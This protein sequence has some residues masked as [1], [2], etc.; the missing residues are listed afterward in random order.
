MKK[1][2]SIIAIALFALSSCNDTL[3]VAPDGRLTLDEVFK[4]EEL[5]KAYFSTCYNYLPKKGLRYHF[6]SNYPIALSDE[7]WDCTDGS[8]AGFA[9]AVS[10]NCT[11][12]DFYLDVRRDM[13]DT[14]SEGGYWQLYWGQIRT[15]NNFLKYA[16]TAAISKDT[17]RKR[18]IA[19][20]H[21]L[22][23]YFY[24]ELLKWYGPV[25]IEKENYGLT[26]DYSGMTRPSFEECARFI[27]D[28]CDIA[29]KEDNLPWRLTTLNERIR[30]TKGIAEAIRSEASLF[31][32]STFNNGGKD[33]WQWAYEVNKKSFDQLKANGYELY[34]KCV[35]KSK[36]YDNAYME[37][38]TLNNYIG[39]DPSDKETIWQSTEG[40]W[41][42][43]YTNPLYDV[44]GSP[45]LGNAIVTIVPSQELVDAYDM[46]ATGKPV[47]DL[48]KPYNDEKHLQPN[49]N[50]N[51]GYDKNNPYEGRDPRLRATV[52]YNNAPV[53]L[54]QTPAV[55]EIYVGGNSELRPSGNTNTRTGYYWRKRMVNGN[56]KAAGV[57]GYDGRFRF[58]RLGKIYLNLAEAAIED[59]KIAEGITLI[60]EIR[61][62]AGFSA[63]VDL[64]TSVSK[65]EAR[66]LVR[67]ERQ[68]ELAC[69]EDRYFDT[70]RWTPADKDMDNEKFTTGVRIT[71]E[72]DTFKY[73]R[74]VVGTDGSKP[75]KM[76]YEK[77]WHLYPIPISEVSVLNEKTGV[78]WQNLG[79]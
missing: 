53:L 25:P 78:N 79:W 48:A 33:L 60:N 7:G 2:I 75:S 76:S 23:A 69:E 9:H 47:L 46:L 51:S 16:E 68:V 19:E 28:E 64:S 41:P 72:G 49:Y 20:A 43:P 52:F 58:Y 13:G 3:D 4:D 66:L 5:T 63:D 8:G 45:V 31:A 17:E 77:K 57:A 10:G 34:T 29:L 27:V 12:S 6:W 55:V 37:Y 70:R 62:R 59:N 61:H 74:F 18:W 24:M 35:D 21:V 67:H 42:D 14:F 38:F 11:T 30:M 39:V 22:R 36:Y 56:C 65:D 44:I 50:P 32:A 73:Q 40:Y 71:K 15:I 1:I 54:G 26:F